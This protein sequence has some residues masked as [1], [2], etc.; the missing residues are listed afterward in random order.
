M[1]KETMLKMSIEDLIFSFIEDTSEEE[2]SAVIEDIFTEYP[3]FD[4]YWDKKELM[5]NLRKRI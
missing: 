5:D 2:I 4:G 3:G 1:D